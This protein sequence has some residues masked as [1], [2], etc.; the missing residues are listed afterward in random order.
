MHLY[1]DPL[2]R[3]GIKSLKGIDQCNRN[4]RA[5]R[6]GGSLEAA[7][8]ERPRMISVFTSGSLRKDQIITTSLH[9]PYYIDND[10]HGLLQVFPVN[11][12]GLHTGKNLLQ[13]WNISHFFLSYHRERNRAGFNDRQYIKQSLVIRKKHKS[14]FLGDVFLPMHINMDISAFDGMLIYMSQECVF[15]LFRI[16][17]CMRCIPAKLDPPVRNKDQIPDHHQQNSLHSYVLLPVFIRSVYLQFCPHI[18][19]SFSERLRKPWYS[20][21]KSWWS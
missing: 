4:D 13:E 19:D 8:L 6:L 12:K 10:L 3:A 9:F 11:D 17:I 7:A 16:I 15:P 18:P 2:C 14:V 5:F 21:Y 1:G 20:L